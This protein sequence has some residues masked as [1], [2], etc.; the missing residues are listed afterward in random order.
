MIT[1]QPTAQEIIEAPDVHY[2]CLD[3]VQWHKEK[4]KELN[5]KEVKQNGKFKRNRISI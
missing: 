3:F 1:K 4:M 2:S 5:T